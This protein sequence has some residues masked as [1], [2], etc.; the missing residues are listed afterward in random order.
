MLTNKYPFPFQVGSTAIPEKYVLKAM[1]SK[2]INYPNT[3]H[4]T[5]DAKDLISQLLE[6]IVEKRIIEDTILSHRWIRSTLGYSK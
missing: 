3:S 2:T 1:N 6:P 4:V 5:K